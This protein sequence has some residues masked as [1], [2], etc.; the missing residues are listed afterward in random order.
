MTSNGYPKRFRVHAAGAAFAAITLSLTMT[1]CQTSGP[2]ADIPTC[3]E[4]AQMGPNTG[5]LADPTQE[6]IEV[7]GV[8]LR[9]SGY[10]DGEMNQLIALTAIIAYC[11][12]YGGYAGGNESS[13]ITDALDLD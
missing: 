13:P 8:A 4:F 11:N 10:D 2:A 12:I 7:L 1:A 5:L 9:D 6:Q 3:Q